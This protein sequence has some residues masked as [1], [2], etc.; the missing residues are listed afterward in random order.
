MAAISVLGFVVSSQV[1]FSMAVM[2]DPLNGSSSDVVSTLLSMLSIIVFFAIDGHLVITGVIV[3]HAATGY[4]VD[5]LEAALWAIHTTDDWVRT[6]LFLRDGVQTTSVTRAIID[7]AGTG[8]SA[9]MLEN[10]NMPLAL[11]C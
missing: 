1:G 8:I 3:M 7:A 9:S 2:N 6:D 5:C 10:V 11:V 4:V